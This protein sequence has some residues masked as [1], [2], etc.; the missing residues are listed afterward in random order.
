MRLYKP[1]TEPLTQDEIILNL[2][3][4]RHRAHAPY[5][6]YHVAAIAEIQLAN[7]SYF[8]TAGVNVECVAHNRLS[9]HGEPN[10]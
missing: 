4:L 6:H 10:P 3:E 9:I 7:G 5:S 2:K 8:Y 1:L